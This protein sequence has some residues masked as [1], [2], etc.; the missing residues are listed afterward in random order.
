MGDMS[1]L[2]REIMDA[3]HDK[4]PPFDKLGIHP[5]TSSGRA[6]SHAQTALVGGCIGPA[7]P[8]GRRVEW[9]GEIDAGSVDLRVRQLDDH[10][11][12]D[13]SCAIIDAPLGHP[14]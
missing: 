6:L 10:D 3:V 12:I 9:V 11:D 1:P 4:H 8:F 2:Q 7:S 14:N 5:S 13:R